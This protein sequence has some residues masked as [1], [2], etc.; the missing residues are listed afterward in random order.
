MMN[1][2]NTIGPKGYRFAMYLG[3]YLPDF[4]EGLVWLTNIGTNA[5]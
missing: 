2:A 5:S 3:N 1:T 4:R